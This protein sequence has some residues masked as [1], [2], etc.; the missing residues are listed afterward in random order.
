MN[1]MAEYLFHEGTNYHSHK[2]LGSFLEEG[3]CTFRVWAPNAKK[4]YVTGDYCSWNPY[5]YEMKLFNDK[6]I[7]EITVPDVKQFDSYKYIIVTESG[8]ELWK[9]DPYAVHAE[10]R[11]KT[12]SKVYKLPEYKWKDDKWMNKRHV[13]YHEPM[14]IYEVHLGSWRHKENGDEF[15]YRELADELVNYVKEMNYTHIELLPVTENPYDKSWRNQVTG[16]LSPKSR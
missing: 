3:V 8:Q 13:P 16:D 4:V 10:T 6:G 11:P 7:Y 1:N 14:N 15:S 5:V 2:F 9:A 12:A